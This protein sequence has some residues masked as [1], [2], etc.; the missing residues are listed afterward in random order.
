MEI[1]RSLASSLRSA[2]APPSQHFEEVRPLQLARGKLEMESEMDAEQQKVEEG[3]NLTEESE[4]KGVT[5]NEASDEPDG[6]RM[7]H[8]RN[9]LRKTI[10]KCIDSAKF[11]TFNKHYGKHM[12]DRNPQALKSL[13]QQFKEQLEKSIKVGPIFTWPTTGCYISTCP[14]ARG[15]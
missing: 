13:L 12:K 4:I 2:T 1:R 9:A 8:L 5:S 10:R 15:K 11:S 6:A 14:I 3:K 7:M